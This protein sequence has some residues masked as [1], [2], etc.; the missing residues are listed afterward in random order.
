M[1]NQPRPSQL[2]LTAPNVSA[3]SNAKTTFYMSVSTALKEVFLERCSARLTFTFPWH[4]NFF[5]HPHQDI[6]AI[7]DDP[8][9]DDPHDHDVG[10]LEF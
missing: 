1:K 5:S 4:Q 9:Q 2:L 7:T 8:D 3:F 10:Q 6:N